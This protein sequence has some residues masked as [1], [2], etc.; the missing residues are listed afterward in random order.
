MI[1]F[2][3]AGSKSEK[4]LQRLEEYLDETNSGVVIVVN[5]HDALR[6]ERN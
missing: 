5:D 1:I 6:V 4:M 2:I 3:K